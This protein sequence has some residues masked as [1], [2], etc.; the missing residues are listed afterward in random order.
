MILV[1]LLI[2]G[3]I[4]RQRQL[5]ASASLP[6]VVCSAN[7]PVGGMLPPGVTLPV[8]IPAGEPLVV[9]TVNGYPLCAEM[10][11]LRVEGTLANH[12]QALQE[13]PPGAPPGLLSTLN[14][15]P[16]QVRHDALTQMIQERLL[17]QEGKRLGL[18]ASESDARAMARQQLQLIDSQPASSPARISFEAFLRANHLTEQ[19]YLNDPQ[20]LSAF[21]TLL[22]IQAMRQRIQRG[23]PPGESPT[24][25]VNAY[26]R[27]LWQTG[28]VRVY[29]PARLGW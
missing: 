28:D 16:N 7:A 23:L 1:T 29:L 17:L 19:T 27:H 22:T 5:A 6:E 14:E 10:L 20:T 26:V 11:E 2:A 4:V 13:G 24:A 18:T 8:K 25:G 3:L 15:T 9:A 12:Q 21:E